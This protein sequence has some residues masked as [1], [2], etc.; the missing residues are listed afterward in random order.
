MNKKKV[1]KKE[2]KWKLICNRNTH[3]YIKII[4]TWR[5]ITKKHSQQK[6]RPRCVL[7]YAVHHSDSFFL[8][9]TAI[10][11]DILSSNRRQTYSQ[12]NWQRNCNWEVTDKCSC[13]AVEYQTCSQE[14]AA[15]RCTRPAEQATNSASYPQQEFIS[16][17]RQI[18]S[19]EVLVNDIKRIIYSKKF[20][21]SY[22]DLYLGITFWVKG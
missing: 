21:C 2:R 5:H 1:N 18:Y 20:S 19:E 15:V 8:I 16:T 7:R 14:V 10:H 4:P 22:D 3:Q 11:P 13:L 17:H 6:A 12:T 9:S